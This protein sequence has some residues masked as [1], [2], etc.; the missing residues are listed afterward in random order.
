MK[1]SQI[2][3][4]EFKHAF[5]KLLH[6]AM[7]TR[8][9]K[10]VVKKV[11]RDLSAE[12]KDYAAK[13]NALIAHYGL[14]DLDGNLDGENLPNGQRRIK[15]SPLSAKEFEVQVAALMDKDVPVDGSELCMGCIAASLTA[16]D[17][18]VLEDLLASDCAV[19]RPKTKLT[20]VKPH[21]GSEA[22]DKPEGDA[23]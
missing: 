3:A 1:I 13:H 6:C 19:C 12:E 10:D 9:Q 22:T 14:R 5:G 23:P 2:I 18:L 17:E 21:V 7:L 4:P 15:I 11:Y 16:S 8:A 20:I